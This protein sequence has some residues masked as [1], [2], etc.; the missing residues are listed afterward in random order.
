LIGCGLTDFSMTP[1]AI[2]MARRVV[3]ETHVGEMGRIA[4][5]VL[6]LGTVDDIEQ[7][8]REAFRDAADTP[9][10]NSR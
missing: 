9:E 5:K 4:A 10:V 7:L 3:E 2:P 1:G 8:L 6:A